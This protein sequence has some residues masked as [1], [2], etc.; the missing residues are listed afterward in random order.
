[1]RI[2]QAVVEHHAAEV[3]PRMRPLQSDNFHLNKKMP[4]TGRNLLWAGRPQLVWPL[5]AAVHH[6]DV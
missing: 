3:G 1:M 2:E 4:V 6:V 5:I